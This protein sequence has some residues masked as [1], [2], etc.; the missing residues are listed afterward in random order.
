MMNNYPHDCGNAGLVQKFIGT[1]YQTVKFVADNMHYIKTIYDMLTQYNMLACVESVEQLKNIDAKQVRFARIYELDGLEKRYVDYA[2]IDND[3]S[4]IKPNGIQYSG[5]WI[6]VGTS[7]AGTGGDGSRDIAW[8]YNNG[9]AQGGEETIIVP[10]QTAAVTCIYVN[11]NY[12]YPRLGFEYDELSQ[13]IRLAQPLEEGDT[14][15]A[16]LSGLP[17]D[18][19][20]PNVDNFKYF[21]WVYN[22]G[23]ANGGEQTFRPPYNFKTVVAVFINGLRKEPQY[24]FTWNSEGLIHLREPVKEND[25]VVIQIGGDVHSLLLPNV[26]SGYTFKG[27][28]T[29]RTINDHIYDS[30]SKK[31]Y[32]W[33]GAYPKRINENTVAADQINANGGIWSN[34]NPLGLWVSTGDT[35]LMT[36]LSKSTG[37]SMIGHGDITVGEKLGQIDTEFNE[38]SLNAGFNKIGRFLNIN[39]LREHKPVN[40][41][42]IVYVASAYSDNDDEHHYGG[43]YFQ[44]FDNSASP[45][46]DDGG[47]VIVPALGNIAWRRINFTVYD[48]CFWGVKP[49]GKT[50]N[51][52][53]I[54]R[55]T[56]YAKNN[57]VILEAPRGDIHTSEAVP[58]YDNMGIKGQGKAEST[59]FYK[60]TNNKFKLKK[61]GNVALEVDALCVFVPEKWDVVDYHMVSFCQRGVLERCM[62]RRLGLTQNNVTAIRPYYG[63]FLGKAASPYIR[64]VQ[65]EGAFI[66]I[67]AFCAFSGIMESVGVSQWNG[68]GYA[69]VDFSN[70]IDGIHNMTGTSMDMRLVQVRGF[71][72]GFTISKLQYSTFIDCT[73]EEISPLDG[74]TI[75]YAF[76]FKDPYCISMLNCATEFITGGQINVVGLA[77]PSFARALKITGYLPI[78]Q[79]NPISP[80]PMF[81]VDSTTGDVMNVVIDACDITRQLNNANL[82]APVVIGANAKVIVIGCAGEDWQTKNSGV[83]NRL[84]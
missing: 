41:G 76:D 25:F 70:Y 21:N 68:Y 16:M 31:W 30:V 19:E 13:T 56:S 75:S 4:G 17:A 47:I 78:D 61:D 9:S 20:T 36:E 23:K 67:K 1:A 45:V 22:N 57:R 27:G 39:K 12:Q 51:A 58:I 52:E 44:S 32:Q 10:E 60:T 50:D 80:T 69:G 54:T 33:I 15:I 37:S 63:L 72:F 59:V 24:H 66:G 40:I 77:N 8:V 2:F 82:T 7:S 49:D 81:S 48:M 74:E 6:K 26:M 18:P 42:M 38:F 64:E 29:L 11:G 55:A 83:F 71:Q 79:Q 53:A 73:A 34:E 65:F 43:G 28:A 14:V 35:G 46:E 84:A 62:F 5:S 3:E